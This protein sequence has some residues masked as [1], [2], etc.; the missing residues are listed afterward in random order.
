MCDPKTLKT[1]ASKCPESIRHVEDDGEVFTIVAV[2]QILEN[3]SN[4]EE[5]G[6]LEN[7]STI[8]DHDNSQGQMVGHTL[9]L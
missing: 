9:P 7:L 3:S 8:F 1:I 5:R 6:W 2:N 4:E